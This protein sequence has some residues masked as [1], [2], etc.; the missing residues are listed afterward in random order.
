MGRVLTGL[1]LSTG[2]PR[3]SLRSHPPC[4]LLRRSS[5][6]SYTSPL[7]WLHCSPLPLRTR[8]PSHPSSCLSFYS[9]CS[10]RHRK[11]A[12]PHVVPGTRTPGTLL[13]RS[14]PGEPILQNTTLPHFLLWVGCILGSNFLK[15]N[16]RHCFS[17]TSG[18]MPSFF[19][20]F[21]FFFFLRFCDSLPSS[22]S[23][24]ASH[25]VALTLYVKSERAPDPEID[26]ALLLYVYSFLSTD[27]QANKFF[28]EYL[29]CARHCPTACGHS[30]KSSWSFW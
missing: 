25:E 20:L 18:V 14:A 21:F 1:H 29:L 5:Y 15:F 17:C 4:H 24:L 23:K 3:S 22:S 12:L 27:C 30:S 8:S 26:K 6:D 16:F 9:A 2:T 19:L 28:T 13:P 7:P 10:R 11:L